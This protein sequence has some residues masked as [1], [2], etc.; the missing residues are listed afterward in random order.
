MALLFAFNGLHSE[1]GA[2]DVPEI[3]GIG[4]RKSLVIMTAEMLRSSMF[5]S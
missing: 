5:Y 4:A 3:T 1:L 2:R